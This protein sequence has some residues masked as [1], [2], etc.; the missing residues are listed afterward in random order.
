LRFLEQ[1]WSFFAVL[2]WVAGVFAVLAG[3]AELGWAI[4][5]V[6]LVNGVFSFHT[7]SRRTCLS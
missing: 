4:F 3:T 6:V 1:F 5:A 7:S 2:L